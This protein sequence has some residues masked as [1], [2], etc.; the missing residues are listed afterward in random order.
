MTDKFCI[1]YYN[2][3]TGEGLDAY[4]TDAEIEAMIRP[5]AERVVTES[6]REFPVMGESGESRLYVFSCNRGPQLRE[7]C[8]KFF[9]RFE[10][11]LY[12]CKWE[13]IPGVN[14]VDQIPVFR[15]S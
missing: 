12:D 8:R 5:Y 6:S 3:E 11:M 13:I 7:L 14:S 2:D 15:N 9:D 1:Y 10:F 4:S